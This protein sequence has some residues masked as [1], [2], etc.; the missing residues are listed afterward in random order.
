MIYAGEAGILMHMFG[1]FMISGTTSILKS[2]H[3]L[4]VS[5]FIVPNQKIDILSFLKKVIPNIS[6]HRSCIQ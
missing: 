2:Y 1:K 5:L 4:G 3:P 6:A